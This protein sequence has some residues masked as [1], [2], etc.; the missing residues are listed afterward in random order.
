MFLTSKQGKNLTI[1]VSKYI[2]KLYDILEENGVVSFNHISDNIYSYPPYHHASKL[3]SHNLFMID[4]EGT[5]SI[6]YAAR[7]HVPTYL[8]PQMMRDCELE[9]MLPY[10]YYFNNLNRI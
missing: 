7:G 2:K 3:F 9:F 8:S 10:N 4:V 5:N 1:D 6:L